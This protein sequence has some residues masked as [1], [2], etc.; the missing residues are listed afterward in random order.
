MVLFRSA[1]KQI[2]RRHGY[3]ASFMCRPRLPNAFSS[4][5]HL[6]QSLIDRE[7]G[8]A[9]AFVSDDRDRLL[10]PL[11]RALPRRACSRMRARPRPSRRRRSTATSATGAYSLAPDRGDLGRATI[12][13]SMVRVLGGP[14]DPATHLENRVG[15]PAANPYLYMA[16]QIIAGLD[17][18][19]RKLDPGP[20]ADT[21][22][23]TQAEPLPKSLGEAL[24]ALRAS[25]CFRHGFGDAF[26]DYFVAIK[27]AEIARF[28]VGGVPNGSSLVAP[29][30]S[31]A[32]VAPPRAPTRGALQNERWDH[33]KAVRIHHNGDP[34]VLRYEDCELARPAAGEARIRHTAIGLNFSDVNVR[35]GGFY[36]AKPL[37]FPV[38]L[39][40]EAAGVV[41]GLGP[42]AVGFAVGDRVVYAG[43][44]A[45]FYERTG[46]YAE[47]TQRPGRA[48]D[49]HPGCDF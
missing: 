36:L 6:H 42:G 3:H 46:S 12:A 20:S 43:M 13:A 28:Q 44:S 27:E 19:E 23:E 26:V 18:I 10:S 41:D 49:P 34:D 45:A 48:P 7:D 29:S 8:K 39:G 40:N 4:G 25:A 11:G 37:E 38:I 24:A 16:S 30:L 47:A 33:M 17:G 2:A 9:N 21:P 1:V 5:W 32:L 31:L 35:R 14:G 15:E 22:Y